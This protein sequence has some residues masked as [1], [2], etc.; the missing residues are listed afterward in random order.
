M[1]EIGYALSS[2][3][4]GPRD[5]VRFAGMAEDAGFTEAWISDHYHP[6]TSTQGHSPFVWAV[7][8]G[9]AATTGLRLGTGVTCPTV[10]IHPAVVAQAAATAAVLLEGRFWLGVGSGEALNEHSPTRRRPSRGCARRPCASRRTPSTRGGPRST[11]APS[12]GPRAS[13]RAA[14]PR[15]R[16]EPG[17]QPGRVRGAERAWSRRRPAGRPGTP[18]MSACSCM[19]SVVDR[20]ARRRP[21]RTSR[22][23][24]RV[25]GHRVGHVAGLVADRLEGRPGEVG[26][27][28][29]PRQPDDHPAGVR[30][31]VRGEQ[32]GERRDE[33]DA[34]GVGDRRGERLGLRGAADDPELV[35]Q[36][37]DR[38]AGD[39]DRAL[40]RST[41]RG[42][43]EAG[44]T[45]W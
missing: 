8:G 24:A 13:S 11:A 12:G 44:S 37:L 6:W 43:A 9:I 14:R 30:A 2:E 10:R 16:P 39:G 19:S 20:R 18:R 15:R 17:G 26:L 1:V 29:E 25:G 34:A 45:R 28:V 21:C 5:L 36:P 27:G 40:Q 23:D 7:I 38:R 3:D 41:R 33:V 32:P 22:C 35:A 42:V 4:H 31:P